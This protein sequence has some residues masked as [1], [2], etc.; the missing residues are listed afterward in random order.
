[1]IPSSTVLPRLSNVQ[2]RNVNVG[3]FSG[4]RPSYGTY[5]LGPNSI[6]ALRRT[7]A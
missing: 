1:M 2:W 7:G 3:M 4:P 5:S 6:D